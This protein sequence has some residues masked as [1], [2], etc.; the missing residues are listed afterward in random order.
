VPPSFG[1]VTGEYLALRESAGLVSG[2]H[3]LIHV[4]GPDSASFLQGLV[5]QDVEGMEIGEVAHSFLLQPQGKLEALLWLGRTVGGFVAFTDAGHGERITALLNRYRIRVDVSVDFDGHS[6]VEIWG[7]DTSAV[8][9]EAGLPDPEGVAHDGDVVVLRA[10]LGPIDRVLLSGVDPDGIPAR[11]VGDVA[12]TAVRVEAGE[13]V[14]GQDVDDKTIPQETGLVARSV[15]FTKGCFVGQELV[16]RIDTRGHVNRRLM[17]VVIGTN[18]IPPSGAELFDGDRKVG[19]LTSPA[20][21]LELRAPIGL[22][23]VR[24]E[25]A[26]GGAVAVRWEGGEAPAIVTTLPLD[27]S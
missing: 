21:S 3:D 4:R 19:V 7:P 6:V 8:L 2:A 18:V 9:A 22:A 26:D 13:P 5:S 17:G 16:A 12:A 1:D 10:Q 15:S 14:M 27:E 11:S 20:E 23:L 24:R 25:V